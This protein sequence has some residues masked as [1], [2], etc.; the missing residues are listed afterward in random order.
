MDDSNRAGRHAP[1]SQR[2]TGGSCSPRPVLCE[3]SRPLYRV[4][5]EMVPR[6]ATLRKR[7]LPTMRSGAGPHFF[8]RRREP[9]CSCARP[10]ALSWVVSLSRRARTRMNAEDAGAAAL[11]QVRVCPRVCSMI[12]PAREKHFESPPPCRALARA[13]RAATRAVLPAREEH[14][15][16]RGRRH[17]PAGDLFEGGAS[18]A[19]KRARILSVV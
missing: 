19:R 16:A 11:E 8:A 1:P 2:C 15:G 14:E 9:I 17:H 7:F 6:S 4:G 13:R 18:P 10:R 3:V 12:M 5:R